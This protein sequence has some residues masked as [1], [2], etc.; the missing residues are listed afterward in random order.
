MHEVMNK[1]NSKTAQIK[2]IMISINVDDI[3][4][5][6]FDGIEFFLISNWNRMLEYISN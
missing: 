4:L 5:S 1:V 2:S 3:L 6:K